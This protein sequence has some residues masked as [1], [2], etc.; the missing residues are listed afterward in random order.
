[1][2]KN[3]LFATALAA[4]ALNTN[5]IGSLSECMTG[6]DATLTD[7]STRNYSASWQMEVDPGDSCW[8]ITFN[9]AY[10][11]WDASQDISVKYQKYRPPFGDQ[12]EEQC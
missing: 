7:I 6:E 11:D 4:M 2:G 10:A 12:G 9:S 3:T 5:A 1:M 8:Y